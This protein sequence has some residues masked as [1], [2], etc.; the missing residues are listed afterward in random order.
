MKG[1]RVRLDRAI[2]GRDASGWTLFSD[3]PEAIAA[4]KRRREPALL[5]TWKD[6]ESLDVVGADVRQVSF[7]VAVH[8]DDG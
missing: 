7:L 5:G 3:M 4:A 1:G 2:G 6:A 8:D